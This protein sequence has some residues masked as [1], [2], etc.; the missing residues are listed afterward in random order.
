MRFPERRQIVMARS[1]ALGHCVCNPAIPCPCETLLNQDLC[2]CAGERPDPT[3][4]AARLTR[5]A[6]KAGCASKIGRADLQRVLERLPRYEDSN[7]LVGVAA[8]DDAGIYRLEGEYN[9]AQTVDVFSP[10][11]DDPFDFGRIC[12]ANSVSDIYA[13]GGRPLCALSIIGFPIDELPHEIMAGILRGGIETLRE[14]G[15]PVIGGHSLQDD[16]IKAGFAVSGLVRGTGLTQA[17]ARPGDALVLTKAI[18][19]GVI[20]FAAQ[21]GRASDD[22]VALITRS[23]VTLNKDAAEAMLERGAHACTDIT[24]FS[25][26]GHLSQMVLHSGV[27]AEIEL[28]KVPLF[29]EALA[30]ARAGIIPGAV[31]RNREAFAE[32]IEIQGAADENELSLFYDAQTSGGLLVALR[33]DQARGY[34]DSLR[35]KGH[36][37]VSIIGTITEKRKYN[38]LIHWSQPERLVGGYREPLPASSAREEEPCCANPPAA[39]TCCGEPGGESGPPFVAVPP[40]TPPPVTKLSEPPGEV[41]EAFQQFMKTVNAPGQVDART[42]KLLAIALSIAQ[43]CEPCLK[44]HLE[45]ALA[46]GMDWETIDEAA[47]MAIAFR[48]AP[49][50]MFYEQVKRQKMK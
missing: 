2:P 18:G 25:L 39:A 1:R 23:M 42:K 26:L 31:E 20:S 13:M 34:V 19:T 50:K 8:G 22:A 41:A 14:A 48:G 47:W 17:G 32:G 35:A 44:I 12:A 43:K 9:L 11:V 38:I 24:G 10:V 21:I 3:G 49:A 33:E 16:E 7:V 37:A 6:S 36:A 29:A 30:C 4:E 5:R 27:S 28:A 46:L 45:S 40:A 15:V